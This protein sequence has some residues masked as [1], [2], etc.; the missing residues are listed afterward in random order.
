MPLPII[1]KYFLFSTVAEAFESGSALD[2]AMIFGNVHDESDASPATVVIDWSDGEF[3]RFIVDTFDVFQSGLGQ[4]VLEM[5]PIE[6][7]L[8]VQQVCVR[9]WQVVDI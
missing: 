1:D 8:S 2:V 9:C 5:Y 6:K 4:K 7:F 3:K